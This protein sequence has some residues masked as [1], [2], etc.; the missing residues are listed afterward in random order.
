MI[1]AIRYAR[2]NKLPFF[3]LC[4]GLQVATIEFA[5]NVCGLAEA[6]STEFRKDDARPG[7]RPHARAARA[8]LDGRHDAARRLSRATSSRSS[9][10][11]RL[12]GT[13]RVIERHRHRYEVNNHY[14]KTLEKH[15]LVFSGN[16]TEKNLVEIIE[17][18]DH[19]WFL[20][21]QFH[22]EFKSKPLE[23]H[24]LFKGFVQAALA[25]AASRAAG[26]KRSV[27]APRERRRDVR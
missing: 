27:E 9:L 3:G 23:P 11:H 6:D 2:E 21:V 8:R 18:P 10:A 22:P 12:Y 4:L 16:F 5:R 20:A 1:E 25:P 7:H 26:P 24:P 14:R 19:P 15:G 17:L 13:D